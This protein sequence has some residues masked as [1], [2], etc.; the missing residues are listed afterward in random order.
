LKTVYLSNDYQR[1]G[2]DFSTLLD[3]GPA[4]TVYLQLLVTNPPNADGGCIL[5][6]DVVA[7]RVDGG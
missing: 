4:Q 3:G 5:V 2:N 6:D 1:L 7:C